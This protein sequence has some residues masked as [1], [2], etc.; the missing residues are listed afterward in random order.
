MLHLFKRETI[1]Q[2]M[3]KELVEA[4]LNL[5]H[6]EAALEHAEV[7]VNLYTVRVNRLKE[8]L[9]SDEH[10]KSPRAVPGP[11]GRIAA[12]STP[13]GSA[14]LRPAWGEHPLSASRPASLAECQ[15]AASLAA[16]VDPFQVLHPVA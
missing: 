15:K 3:E 10:A 7:T 9:A 5:L 14:V 4:E 6:A 13:L 16:G 11:E 12:G 1:K 2:L 8:R